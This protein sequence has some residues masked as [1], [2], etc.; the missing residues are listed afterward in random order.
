MQ[1]HQP[2]IQPNGEGRGPAREKFQCHQIP[3]DCLTP[4]AVA[5]PC[6]FHGI[7]SDFSVSRDSP[8]KEAGNFMG[9]RMQEYIAVL[10]R[11]FLKVDKLAVGSRKKPVDSGTPSVQYFCEKSFPLEDKVILCTNSEFCA[12]THID[13]LLS[14]CSDLLLSCFP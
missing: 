3:F 1:A 5:F 2:H 6:P 8:E 7:T 12:H 13:I 4:L 14:L 10:Q 11:Y 9:S